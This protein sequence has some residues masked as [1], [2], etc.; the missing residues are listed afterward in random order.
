MTDVLEQQTDQA[1]EPMSRR[2]LY[3]FS[4]VPEAGGALEVADGVLWMRL[5]LPMQLNHI[6]VYAVRDNDGWAVVDTGLRTPP[7]VEAWEALLT[8]PLCG[9]PV[10]RVI[11]TH[12]HPDHLGLAGW[13]CERFSAPLLMSRLEYVTARMLMA[14]TGAEP[15]ECGAAFYRAAGWNA[16]QIDRWSK[17]YGQ[18]GMAVAALPQSYQRLIEGRDLR[19]GDADWTVVV[20]EGHSPEHVCL[21]RKSDG[22]LLGGDQ[23]LPRISSNVSVWPT[24]PLSDPLGDWLNSLKRMIEI[25]DDEV[26]VLPSHGEPFRG[27]KPR[28]RAL[29]RGHEVSLKR[30]ERT[31]T[32]PRRSVDVFGAL[33]ARPVDGGL[34]SMATGEAIAH[35]NY[36]EVEG[37]VQ[38]QRDAEGV[39]W[40]QLKSGLDPRKEMT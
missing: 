38:R 24:E 35:L 31:L 4:A 28:L 3:P 7:T 16:E 36:L 18:F 33:F 2:L 32:E 5:P 12:L 34:L 23:I 22:V 10:T 30:L 14:D 20:G 25:L 37:R 21:W 26:L 39:D 17:G 6:N 8:G 11:V 29:I 40:W 13:L 1:V 15:P 19:I 27:V 9:K